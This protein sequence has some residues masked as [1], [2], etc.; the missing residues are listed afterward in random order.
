MKGIH[1]RYKNSRGDSG[2]IKIEDDEK[3]V[4]VLKDITEYYFKGSVKE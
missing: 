1:I 2:W 4:I 3:L